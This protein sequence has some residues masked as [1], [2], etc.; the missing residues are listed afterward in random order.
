MA[1]FQPRLDIWAL[2]P[3][4]RK[5]LQPGQHITAGGAHGVYLGQTSGGSDVA[6]WEASAR[7]G[8]HRRQRLQALRQYAKANA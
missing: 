5:A 2:S 6:L 7:S 4:Q 8:A 3:D 1:Q